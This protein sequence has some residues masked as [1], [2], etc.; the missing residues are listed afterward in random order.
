MGE[1]GVSREFL[2]HRRFFRR[3]LPHIQPDGGIFFVSSNVQRELFRHGQLR[4]LGIHDAPGILVAGRAPE[5]LQ[6]ELHKHDGSLYT[7]YAYVIMPD[8]LHM[9]IKPACVHSEFVSLPRIMHVLKRT[10]AFRINRELERSG[11]L[12]QYEYYDNVIR[13]RKHFDRVVQYIRR[14]PVAEGLVAE[15]EEWPWLWVRPEP[16][17]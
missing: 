8:H 7:L 10:S 12:W 15:P 2:T 6:N 5:L 16:G 17:V 14:N 11:R 9:L 1:D 4:S 13:S 3:H